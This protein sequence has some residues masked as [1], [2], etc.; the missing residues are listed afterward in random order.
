MPNK[1]VVIPPDGEDDVLLEIDMSFDDAKRHIEKFRPGTTLGRRTSFAYSLK[2]LGH[3][4]AAALG[5]AKQA[6]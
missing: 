2:R 5:L 6:T 3:Q 4:L 1:Y